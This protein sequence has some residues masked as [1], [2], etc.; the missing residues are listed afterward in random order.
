MLKGLAIEEDRNVDNEPA[1]HPSNCVPM[2]I[3]RVE[4]APCK[5]IQGLGFKV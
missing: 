1:R 5:A 2:R 4:S 3:L